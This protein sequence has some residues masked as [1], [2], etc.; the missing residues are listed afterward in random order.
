ELAVVVDAREPRPDEV[1][2]AE[3]VL[4]EL[5]DHVELRVE[6]VAAE[7]EPVALV[8]DRPRDPADHVVRLEDHR[9]GAAAREA[10]GRR[11]ARGACAEDGDL[12]GRSVA[13]LARVA[14][15]AHSATSGDASSSESAKGTPPRSSE[16]STPSIIRTT[17]TPSVGDERGSR[18]STIAPQKS[19]S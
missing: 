15:L 16:R 4:P 9:G 12:P 6:P 7:I 10:V 14:V 1:V 8:L 11:Q 3:H 18:P 13:V 2:V 19:A 5:V 17:S